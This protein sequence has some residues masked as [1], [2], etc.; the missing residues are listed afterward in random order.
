[1]NRDK[2]LNLAV[3]LLDNEGYGTDYLHEYIDASIDAK[4]DLVNILSR[5]PNWDPEMGWIHFKYDTER[6]IDIKIL[7]DFYCWVQMNYSCSSPDYDDVMQIFKHATY[8]NDFGQYPSEAFVERV[9]E[10]LKSKSAGHITKET[11]VSKIINKIGKL[12]GLSEIV[13][14]EDRSYYDQS[15]NYHKKVKDIG[16][17][18][19]FALFADGINP[20]KIRRHTLISVNP[21]DFLTMSIG[22]NWSSCHDIRD[23]DEPGCYSAGTMSY[24]MDEVSIIF[25][26]VDEK[27]NDDSNFCLLPKQKRCVF[28]YGEEK[29]I[30]SRVYPDGRDGG[31]FGIAEETRTIMQ[32]VLADCLDIPNLW[33]LKK[34]C[35]N[36]SEIAYSS[37]Y[38]YTD[39][40]RYNDCTTS[41]PKAFQKRNGN[42]LII[43]KYGICPQCGE[44]SNQES[45]ILCI[46]CSKHYDGYCTNCENGYYSDD[47]I[48]I[49]D[50]NH[51]CCVSCAEDAGYVWI[52]GEWYDED[53]VY[54]DNLTGEMFVWCDDSSVKTVYG[55]CYVNK[56]HA[57][58]DGNVFCRDTFDWRYIDNCYQDAYTKMWYATESD[59]Y[60]IEV[61]EYE[62][63]YYTAASALAMGFVMN[64]SGEWVRK[65][66]LEDEV[67]S[68]N[69]QNETATAEK[70]A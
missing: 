55:E 10:Y 53:E 32:K 59:L 65:E 60:L 43:G 35:E 63:E 52:D 18:Y 69:M 34:G 68:E 66:D 58:K 54:E 49:D 45:N 39:Y 2:I 57:I 24:G 15:G 64:D 26:Y 46:S 62:V 40:Y 41:Y 31:D 70:V 17:N 22:D 4:Q 38:Q 16:W 36:I 61:D 8:N 7:R 51:F 23:A 5:H 12:T 42:R 20:L 14:M 21:I 30:Q 67:V 1:M 3:E 13:Q 19:Q 9:N 27:Y 37:G 56:D 6:K 48:W 47:E 33:E 25:Y 28:C 44:E 50:D 11:R 29:L